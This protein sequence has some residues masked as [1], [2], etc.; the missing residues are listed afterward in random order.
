MSLEGIIITRLASTTPSAEAFVLSCWLNSYMP[1]GCRAHGLDPEEPRDRS[2]YYRAHHPE[3]TRLLRSSTLALAA[4]DEDPDVYLGWALGVP[5]AGVLHYVFVKSDARGHGIAD[6]LV[7]EA[8][9]EH[10]RIHTFEPS[11]RKGSPNA[12]LLAVAQRR[13][14]RFHPHPIPGIAQMLATAQRQRD[15]AQR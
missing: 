2:A 9:G 5:D 14:M 1:R 10:P 6:A 8:A 12:A 3:F 11:K 13:G 15:A 7:R 4:V